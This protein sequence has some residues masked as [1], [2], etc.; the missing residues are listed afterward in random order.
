MLMSHKC[1]QDYLYFWCLTRSL[2]SKC[3]LMRNIENF[4]KE[5]QIPN[6]VM[7]SLINHQCIKTIFFP[8]S[9]NFLSITK[10]L[11]SKLRTRPAL[12]VWRY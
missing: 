11:S 10:N 6:S 5:F 12:S 9:I 8:Q 2:F 4:L 7:L 1:L 3:H